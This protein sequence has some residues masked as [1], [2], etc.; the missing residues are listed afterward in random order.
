MRSM[1]KIWIYYLCIAF[2]VA[3][4]VKW[5]PVSIDVSS[6]NLTDQNKEIIQSADTIAMSVPVK[7]KDTVS[8]QDTLM[9]SQVINTIASDSVIENR[10]LYSRPA[11]LAM[12]SE[13]YNKLTVSADSGKII[14]I[15]HIGDSQVE[16]DRITRYL[17]ESFQERFGGSGPGLITVYDPARMNPSIWLNNDG[18]WNLRTVYDRQHHDADNTYGLM[19]IVAELSEGASGS[20]KISRSPWAES[21]AAHYQKVRLFIAPRKDTLRITGSIK[22]RVV[23]SD[24]LSPSAALTEISWVF[25]QLSPALKMHFDSNDMVRILGCALDSTGGV[26]VDNIA[27]RGQNT[28]LLQRTDGDVFKAMADHLNVGMIIFQF[29]TNMIPTVASNYNF[30][31]KILNRQ[32]KLL[33]AYLP[34]TPV[35]VVGVADAAQW[36][37]GELKSYTHISKIRD[38]Q[39]QI[40]LD[41]G[42]AFFDLYEAMG[43]AGKIIEWADADPPL[44]LSD[45]IHFT[46]LGG[47]K[48]A[49][50]LWSPLDSLFVDAER[51]TATAP[52][53]TSFKDSL[54]W[55]N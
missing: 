40:T 13:L 29:G 4:M 46:K 34:N 11:F 14:R 42:F 3:V 33:K 37:D 35:I 22:K 48:A 32:F 17:R 38:A 50:M 30:Y 5:L 41:N 27:L 24:T 9:Q 51:R 1:L 39:K 23:I 15:L 47:K 12:L 16:G 55:N 31:K 52:L 45:Y 18:D 8:A 20:V 36:Q 6:F 7:E 53:F 26:A 25:P 49:K 43:G 44:A 10:F 28:P 19:G 54:P 21:H 2:L